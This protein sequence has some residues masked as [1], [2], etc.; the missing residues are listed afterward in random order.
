MRYA[1]LCHGVT[2]DNRKADKITRQKKVNDLTWRGELLTSGCWLMRTN[3]DCWG[4]G[5]IHAS[6]IISS[7]IMF[8]SQTAWCGAS[9]HLLF[10][11]KIDHCHTLGIGSMSAINSKTPG[12]KS[13]HLRQKFEIDVLIR[14]KRSNSTVLIHKNE[15]IFL[16]S[17]KLEYRI[18][19]EKSLWFGS[20]SAVMTYLCN[21]TGHCHNANPGRMGISVLEWFCGN[22]LLFVT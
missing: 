5:K 16:R 12:G 2:Q 7:I 8:M 22:V 15:S 18:S 13:M 9:L 1:V 20:S 19:V 4:P 10:K 17:Y 6:V 3:R 21:N 11:R 14:G